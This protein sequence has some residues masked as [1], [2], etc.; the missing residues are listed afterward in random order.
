[1]AIHELGRVRF[2][3][4]LDDKNISALVFHGAQAL[5][6]TDEKTSL[7]N[8]LQVFDPDGD[9]FRAAAQGPIPLDLPGGEP[10][11]MDLEGIAA[12][13]DTVF[14]VGSHSA[15][16]KK[17]DPNATVDI[18]RK[19]L[20]KPPKLEPARD[21]LLRVTLA[22]D[23]SASAIDRTSLRE[24][25]DGTDPFRQ[26]RGVASKENG[27]DIEGLAVFEDH[28]YVG[29]RGPVLRGNFTPIVRCRFGSPIEAPVTRF[30][31]LGGRGVRD[32]AEVDDHLL[33]LAGPVGDGPGSYQV[34]RWDGEDGVPGNGTPATSVQLLG[35]LPVPDGAKAEGLAVV[36]ETPQHWD[37]LVVFD[38]LADDGI[39]YRVDKP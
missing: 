36:D 11:E 24:F 17:I 30:V 7:G 9:G 18:N 28:L 12:A 35:D 31:N 26:F 3:G 4:A 32:L 21:V 37:L 10:E 14:I 23:G 1:M 29:F 25:L 16:R 33:I 20:I 38:G 27:P 39:R 2:Q 22:A 15:K 13:G 34:Y 8:V 6:V 5:I 19:A